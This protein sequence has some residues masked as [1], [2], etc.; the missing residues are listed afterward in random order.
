MIR[1]LPTATDIK[2]WV[3]EIITP[4]RAN[5]EAKRFCDII[6]ACSDADGDWQ[7]YELAEV[8]VR[9]AFSKTTDFEEAFKEFAGRPKTAQREEKEKVSEV[10]ETVN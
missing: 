5:I 9:H 4:E 10:S 6:A 3:D 1:P 2:N 8:A 7:S